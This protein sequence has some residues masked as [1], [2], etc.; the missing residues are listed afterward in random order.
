M[1]LLFE[2]EPAQGIRCALPQAL[3]GALNCQYANIVDEELD[4]PM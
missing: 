3:L 2:P 4:K 1:E